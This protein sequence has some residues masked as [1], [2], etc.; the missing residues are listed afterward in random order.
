M[1]EHVIGHRT[2][3]NTDHPIWAELRRFGPKQWVVA[4]VCNGVAE[5]SRTYTTRRDAMA[6]FEAYQSM[7]NPGALAAIAK[8]KLS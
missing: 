1:R 3:M 5:T 8:G 6:A 2:I 4:L 7:S